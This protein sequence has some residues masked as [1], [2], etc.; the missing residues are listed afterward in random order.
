MVLGKD[1]RMLSQRKMRNIFIRRLDNLLIS[2]YNLIDFDALT[3]N[4][5]HKTG[6]NKQCKGII[7]E[8]LEYKK[9]AFLLLE[10]MRELELVNV[11]E[12]FMLKEIYEEYYNDVD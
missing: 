7:L 3:L 12:Y 8:A 9:Q 10:I 2:Y 6:E 4:K 1:Y 11:G 5:F